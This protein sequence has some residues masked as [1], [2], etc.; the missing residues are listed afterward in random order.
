M[1]RGLGEGGGGGAWT[2]VGD[3]LLHGNRTDV[4]LGYHQELLEIEA[5][6]AFDFVYVPSVSRPDARDLADP[7]LGAGRANN[8]LRHLFGLP[9]KDAAAAAPALPRQRPL[10]MLRKRIDPAQTVLLCCG[11]PNCMADIA[12]IAAQTG[13]R[14]G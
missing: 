1:V 3:P 2:P 10:E 6:K 8:L 7:Q 4:E 9:A 14:V 12:W 13:V 11:N 5:S